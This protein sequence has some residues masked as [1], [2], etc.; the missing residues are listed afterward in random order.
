[1]IAAFDLKGGPEEVD[2]DYQAQWDIGKASDRLGRGNFTSVC[3]CGKDLNPY[4][5]ICKITK[6]SVWD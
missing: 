6:G 1:M 4:P 2:C 5:S 3:E